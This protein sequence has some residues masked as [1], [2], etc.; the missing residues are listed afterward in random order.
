MRLKWGWKDRRLTMGNAGVARLILSL[1]DR[2]VDLWTETSMTDLID[3]NGSV[4]GIKASQ[5]NTD[6]N[7]TAEEPKSG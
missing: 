4:T 5:N 7:I 6:I 1:Q 3:E 2:N